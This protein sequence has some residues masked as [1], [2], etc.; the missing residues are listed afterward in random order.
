MTCV[1]RPSMHRRFLRR[2]LVLTT[3]I[4]T[5]ATLC[6][7]GRV[8]AEAGSHRL[9]PRLD[10]RTQVS[11]MPGSSCDISAGGPALEARPATCSPDLPDAPHDDVI[12]NDDDG[13][14]DDDSVGTGRWRGASARDIATREVAFPA[15]RI[16]ISWSAQDHVFPRASSSSVPELLPADPPHR[17][18]ILV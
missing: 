7:P 18:P 8:D 13:V 10:T 3:A 16:C 4:A 2:I 9:A 12:A 6:L 17:P 11:L 14:D 1:A 15:S 5:A